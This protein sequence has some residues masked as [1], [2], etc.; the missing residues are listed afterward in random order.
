MA[1]SQVPPLNRLHRLKRGDYDQAADLQRKALVAN[2]Q[3][4]NLG[5]EGMKVVGAATAGTLGDKGID[6]VGTLARAG[7][8][9]V[10]LAVQAKRVTG[11]VGPSLVR[12]LRGSLAPGTYGIIITTGY[13]TQA[14]AAAEADR[15]D[16]SRIKLVDG[17]E[18]ARVLV[19]SG[20][21]V[22]I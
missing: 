6:I 10:R 7:L 13:F 22:K 12:Q 15:T 3:L 19:D 20:I 21:G 9:A 18:L 4:G 16:V 1:H 2:R 11:A 14:A 17:T 5:C 8:P